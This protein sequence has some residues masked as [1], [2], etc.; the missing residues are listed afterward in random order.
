MTLFTQLIEWDPEWTYMR[1]RC[2]TEDGVLGAE[3]AL[4]ALFV[5]RS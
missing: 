1:Q 3:A 5:R 2:E 4:R